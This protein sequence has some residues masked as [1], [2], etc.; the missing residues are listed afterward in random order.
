[1]QNQPAKLPFTPKKNIQ[2][3]LAHITIATNT[4]KQQ[5]KATALQGRKYFTWHLCGWL[6]YKQQVN[7]PAKLPFT[8]QKTI[9]KWLADITIANV[10]KQLPVKEFIYIKEF[11]STNTIWERKLFM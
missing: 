6:P 5:W 1:M 3:W 2:N 11:L 4:H 8:P 9:Q 10:A 7:Q